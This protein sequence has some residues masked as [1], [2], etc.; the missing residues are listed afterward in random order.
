MGHATKT[1]GVV[2]SGCGFLDGSEIHEA[3]LT[4]LALD[5]R[6]AKVVVLAPDMAQHHVV[7]HVAKKPVAGERRV[8]EE[9]ARIARGHVRPLGSVSASE[10]D[11]LIF[12]GGAGAAKNLS[13][14]AV[15]GVQMKV[16]DDVAALIREVHAAKKPLGF[17]CIAP[18]LAAKVLGHGVHLTIGDDPETAAAIEAFGGKHVARKVEEI[19]VDP[20]K[21]V[22]ST[23]AYMFDTSI[24]H[25]QKG[26]DRLVGAVLELA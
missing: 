13:T 1:V 25:V 5:Q 23:P 22:V 2:L 12:P 11:A 3:T 14:W 24:A 15:D 18:V 16:R 20:A 9:S 7:N 4:L 26:I 6:G 8:L 19:E 21:K 10:L 17:I